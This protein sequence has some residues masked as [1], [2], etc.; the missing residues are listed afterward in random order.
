MISPQELGSREPIAVFER[1]DFAIFS[2]AESIVRGG[3]NHNA[4]ET[5]F[6]KDVCGYTDN[7]AAAC[8]GATGQP[9]YTRSPAIRRVWWT[10][11]PNWRQWLASLF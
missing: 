10:I 11:T 7:P 3:L 5:S 8:V 4:H 6:P 2:E 9:D 1:W